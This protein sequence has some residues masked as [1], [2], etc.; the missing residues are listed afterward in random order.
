MHADFSALPCFRYATVYTMFPVF[1][2]VLDED[3][4]AEIA[5]IYPEL[6]KDLAK[7]RLF[8]V[9]LLGYLVL[10]VVV[11][12]VVC[13]CGCGCGCGCCCCCFVLFCFIR[14]T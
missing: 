11:V 8:I 2:L 13:C 5:M 7:V 12:V 3:V 1:S 9:L 14:V 10:L 6:Y 4:P